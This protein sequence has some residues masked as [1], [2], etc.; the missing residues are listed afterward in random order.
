MIDFNGLSVLVLAPHPDDE[1]FGCG[2][3][4]HRMV[5]AGARVYVLYL[6]NGTTEHFADSGRSTAAQRRLEIDAVARRLGFADTAIALEGDDYHLQLDSVPQKTLIDVIERRSPLSIETLEPDLL[7]IPPDN[8]YNQDH[9]AT[10]RAAVTALRPA[11]DAYRHFCPTVLCYELPYHQWQP[12]TSEPIPE[13]LVSLSDDDMQARLDALS[14]YLSQ[15]K[16][17]VSPLSA[18]GIETLARFRGLQAN[19]RYAEAFR[20][21]RLAIR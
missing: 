9:R 7:L 18:H 13:C 6:T 21:K 17:D 5:R 10:H 8:D 2:G 12:G 4:L 14:L 3:T 19:A 20:L 1:V 15:L 11:A 16:S